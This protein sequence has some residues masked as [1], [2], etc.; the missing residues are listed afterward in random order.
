[1]SEFSSMNKQ[2]LLFEGEEG[3]SIY[4][5]GAVD[6]VHGES[7]FLT[8]AC[9]DKENVPEVYVFPGDGLNG[10]E[11]WRCCTSVPAEMLALW[12]LHNERI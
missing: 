2:F 5:W 11:C 7:S 8:H 3:W 1:M 4:A 9:A 6:L 12:I 10:A